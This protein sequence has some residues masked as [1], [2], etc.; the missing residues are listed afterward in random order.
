MKRPRANDGTASPAG[1]DTPCCTVNPGWDFS[2]RLS[3]RSGRPGTPFDVAQPTAQRRG[4]YG[5]TRVNTA[6]APDDF[7]LD[8]RFAGAQIITNRQNVAGDAWNRGI[9]RVALSRQP[10][11]FPVIGLAWEV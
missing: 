4:L 10:G 6:R 3:C 11:S 2:A 1:N 7:R 8:V 5:I 9:S